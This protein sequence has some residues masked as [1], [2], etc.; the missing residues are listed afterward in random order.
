MIIDKLLHKRMKCKQEKNIID[1]HKTKTD[2]IN[3]ISLY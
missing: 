3:L 2:E 1:K